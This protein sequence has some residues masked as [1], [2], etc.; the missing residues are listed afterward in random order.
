[1]LKKTSGS[2]NIQISFLVLQV[3]IFWASEWIPMMN[4]DDIGKNHE[5]YTT[6]Y[7]GHGAVTP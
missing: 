4:E 5:S 6:F 1:M 2:P 7:H 3:K